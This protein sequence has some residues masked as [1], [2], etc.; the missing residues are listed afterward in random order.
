MATVYCVI[1][2]A[3]LVIGSAGPS[4]AGHSA[5]PA[6]LTIAADALKAL[7]DQGVRPVSVD[8]RPAAE[9]Q[10]GRLPGARSIPLSELERRWMEVPRDRMI[11]LYCACPEQ[12]VRPAYYFLLRQ[13]YRE[14]F[15]L[16]D[17]IGAWM[18]HGYPL[19]R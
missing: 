2:I 9:H 15:V 16:R 11:V 3:V 17:G 14:V 12:T 4:V 13:G 7:L 10:L 5:P 1:L 6:L 19:E 8:L 18:A